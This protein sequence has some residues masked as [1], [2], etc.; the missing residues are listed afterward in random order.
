MGYAILTRRQIPAAD[1]P[2]SAADDKVDG[3]L[4]T[5]L[6]PAAPTYTVPSI[7]DTFRREG[8]R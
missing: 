5:L 1:Y 6:F 2:S 8:Y 7:T 3:A 4:P